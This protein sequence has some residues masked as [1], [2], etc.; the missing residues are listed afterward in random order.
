MTKMK[1]V[2]IIWVK[3]ALKAGVKPEIVAQ[4]MKMTVNELFQIV[5]T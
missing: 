2:E 4:K 5:E 3:D 1:R